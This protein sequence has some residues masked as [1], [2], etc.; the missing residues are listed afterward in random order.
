MRTPRRILPLLFALFAALL[1]GLASAQAVYVPSRIGDITGLQSSLNAKAAV[2]NL[3]V[4]VRDYGATADLKWLNKVT[5]T[6]GSNS[7][8]VDAADAFNAG[9]SGFTAADIGKPVVVSIV[10][11]AGAGWVP[12]YNA[13]EVQ[14]YIKTVVNSTTI[15]LASDRGLTTNL[16]LSNTTTESALRY[17]TDNTAAFLAALAQAQI[18]SHPRGITVR[19]PRG[20]YMFVKPPFA[21]SLAL[22][23]DAVADNFTATAHGLTNGRYVYLGASAMPTGLT[24]GVYFVVNA[25]ANTFQLSATP[26]G[27]PVLFTTAG[28]SVTATIENVLLMWPGTRLVGEGRGG[29]NSTNYATGTW[30][31]FSHTGGNTGY[32]ALALT[33]GPY[34]I[35]SVQIEGISWMG[36]SIAASGWA[37]FGGAPR[38][39]DPFRTHPCLYLALYGNHILVRDC[40][41]WGF[42]TQIESQY[43]DGVTLEN[44][45]HRRARI[46]AIY[47]IGCT[48][49][50]IR[51]LS[52][53]GNTLT[54]SGTT[55]SKTRN[56]SII[57]LENAC[58]NGLIDTPIVDE[59]IKGNGIVIRDGCA[60]IV[61]RVRMMF[62]GDSNGMTGVDNGAGVGMGGALRIGDDGTQTESASAARPCTNITIQGGIIR[63]YNNFATAQHPVVYVHSDAVNVLFDN[64]LLT[65]YSEV[66]PGSANSGQAIISDNSPTTVYQNC[67]FGIDLNPVTTSVK[68]IRT[69]TLSGT[70]AVALAR[71]EVAGYIL[72]FTG[73]PTATIVVTAPLRKGERYLIHNQ[74]GQSVTFGHTTGTAVSVTAGTR[75]RVYFDG[76]NVVTEP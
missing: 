14:G 65:N 42:S 6:N 3:E 16:N 11:T 28:T 33:N 58:T 62:C 32:R 31:D 22:T 13:A 4:N 73:S 10:I 56:Y 51:D 53:A 48:N 21:G 68:G 55:N 30:L 7:V 71:N 5:T 15:T 34:N 44:N 12:A 52:Y 70:A 29:E 49:F 76:T 38:G 66:A 50:Q 27:S 41:F 26:G 9:W 18:I 72:E 24:A 60:N 39:Q 20:G 46:R 1:P 8:S 19:V 57:T 64:V 37:Q 25:T 75:T 54:N 67:R 40:S 74:T 17:G 59:A 23:A 69:R 2:A 43:T 35:G 36:P 63:P 47:L 45:Y 61:V